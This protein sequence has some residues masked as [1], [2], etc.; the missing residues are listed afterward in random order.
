MLYTAL[1]SKNLLKLST[2]LY[3]LQGADTVDTEKRIFKSSVWS[4][5]LVIFDVNVESLQG[6]GRDRD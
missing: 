3:C 1:S 5:K 2:A 4:K 6:L